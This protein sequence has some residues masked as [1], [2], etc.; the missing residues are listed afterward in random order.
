MSLYSTLDFAENSFLV[1]P[2]EN[3]IIKQPVFFAAAHE[4]Y[5]C[6]PKVGL[7]TMKDACP[8]LTV[9][10]YQASHVCVSTFV[11]LRPQL[12]DT[13]QWV[14]LTAPDKLNKDLLDWIQSFP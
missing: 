9:R 6:A 11:M 7:V 14:Q 12:I 3:Y 1:V 5:I 10:D 8:N 2:K 13:S 4:D